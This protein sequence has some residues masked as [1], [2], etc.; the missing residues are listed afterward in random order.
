VI[1]VIYNVSRELGREGEPGIYTAHTVWDGSAERVI[2]D[3]ELPP[4]GLFGHA[5][6]AS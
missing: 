6:E 1:F 3:D 4:E 5:A 2:P